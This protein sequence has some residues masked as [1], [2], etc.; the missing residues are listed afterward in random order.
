MCQKSISGFI[1]NSLVKKQ[2]Y[3]LDLKC[4]HE[5]RKT[6]NFHS[7]FR[8]C[9]FSQLKLTKYHSIVGV[10]KVIILSYELF[11]YLAPF[12]LVYPKKN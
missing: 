7:Y 2:R 1:F 11:I 10:I 5:N 4:N 9:R 8:H 6:Y 12:Y 3:I